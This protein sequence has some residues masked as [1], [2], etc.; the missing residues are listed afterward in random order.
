M[1]TNIIIGS[2]NFGKK[3]GELQ[4]KIAEKEVRKL[5]SYAIKKKFYFIDTATSYKSS[6]S[7]IKKLSK[8]FGLL[9]KILPNEKWINYEICERKIKIIKKRFNNKKIDTVMFHDEKFLKN[10]YAPEIFKN[11]KKL[12]K[13]RFF[14][15]IGLSI[16]NFDKLDDIFTKFKFDV[17]QC[18]FNVFD[19]RLIS[20]GAYKRMKARGIKVHVRSIFLQGLLLKEKLLKKKK[21]KL[22]NQKI[23]LLKK[24]SKENNINVLDVCLSF[25]TSYKIDKYVIGFENLKNFKEVIFFRKIRRIDFKKFS[26]SK[27]KLIDP[28][29]WN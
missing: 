27:N 16:Y 3:Y 5:C 8:K 26:L 1:L 6:E 19:Q 4:S 14:K 20:S 17:I 18:P 24:F 25:V 10:K 9:I 28:R 2:A 7:I 21:F 13:N 29:K 15:N 23:F 22:L 11:L 12:K